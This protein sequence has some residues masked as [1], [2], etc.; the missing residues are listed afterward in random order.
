MKGP[1]LVLRTP[2]IGLAVDN[3]DLALVNWCQGLPSIVSL[4]GSRGIGSGLLL[5]GLALLAGIF[6][7][8]IAYSK[9][10]PG[11]QGH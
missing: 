6:G 1:C 7:R 11:A 5:V 2:V 4:V 9:C 10:H 8:C 3:L